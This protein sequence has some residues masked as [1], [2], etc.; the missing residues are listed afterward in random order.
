MINSKPYRSLYTYA[1]DIL[2]IGVKNFV[3]EVLAMGITDVTLATSYHAGKFIRP[4]AKNPPRVIFPEDGVVYFNPNKDRYSD[5]QPQAHSDEA[6]RKILPELLADARL[7]IHGWTVLLHN[8]RIGAAYPKYT[9]KN[10]FGDPYVYSLCPMQDAVFDYAVALCRDLSEQYALRS[11]V[12]ETPGWLPFEHGYHH[13]FAQVAP[14]AEIN[15]LLGLCFCDAC[16]RAAKA[17]DIKIDTLQTQVQEH[18]SAFL[19]APGS[20]GADFDWSNKNMSAFIELRQARVTH[21]VSAIKNILPSSTELAVIPTVQRPTKACWT[22]GSEL[23]ALAQ[24]ADYL[25]IPFYEPSAQR[26]LEDAEECLKHIP[27]KKISAILRPGLPDLNQGAELAT[28]M[29]GLAN[30]GITEFAF[31]NYGL[32]PQS[33]LDKLAATLLVTTPQAK[34]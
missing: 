27:A 11:L 1:W 25:E 31:Y 24:V 3:E 23:G 22:E 10:A 29:Q 34:E 4:H 33:G 14:S 17:Q 7:R 28:A 30:L 5:I 9:V 18:I 12:L 21:L 2:D 16:T 26:V 32:L 15:Q 19:S 8:S 20:L 13:E 6:I